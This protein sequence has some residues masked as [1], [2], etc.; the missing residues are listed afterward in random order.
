MLPLSP[1]P[2]AMLPIPPASVTAPLSAIASPLSWFHACLQGASA[3][4]FVAVRSRSPISLPTNSHADTLSLCVSTPLSS[5]ALPPWPGLAS[6][7]FVS[8]AKK[9]VLDACTCTVLRGLEAVLQV[10][11]VFNELFFT[12]PSPLPCSVLLSTIP[13]LDC[14]C[15]SAVNCTGR[16]FI[17]IWMYMR[18]TGA[19]Q[20]DTDKYLRV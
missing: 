13:L 16:T 2:P 7:S 6:P 14:R 18:S 5:P 11:S 9:S 12:A 3:C 15:T 17:H 19:R 1:S 8:S 20:I 4:L 10:L